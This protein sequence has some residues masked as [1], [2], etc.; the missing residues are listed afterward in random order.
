MVGHTS[1]WQE[2]TESWAEEIILPR[3][4]GTTWSLLAWVPLGGLQSLRASFTWLSIFQL[5]APT[6]HAA[7][8]MVEF[9]WGSEST[10]RA[11]VIM[12]HNYWFFTW[13][14][15][16]LQKASTRASWFQPLST[17]KSM[18]KSKTELLPIRKDT[19]AFVSFHTGRTAWKIWESVFMKIY[20]ESQIADLLS[21]FA[22]AHVFATPDR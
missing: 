1:G 16:L 5:I 4:S 14:D 12:H 3:S 6:T 21:K 22:V 18:A 13:S 19:N 8:R 11:Q 15:N 17:A 20:R 7:D 10:K 9:W 2:I